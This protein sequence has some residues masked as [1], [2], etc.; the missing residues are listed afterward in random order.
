MECAELAGWQ[1]NNFV[2]E[3]A[4]KKFRD[5]R[6]EPSRLC[7]D[8]TFIRRAFLDSIGFTDRYYRVSRR[9]QKYKEYNILLIKL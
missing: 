4:E 5:L 9:E 3:L 8:A 7:D 6:I 2:D 1:N